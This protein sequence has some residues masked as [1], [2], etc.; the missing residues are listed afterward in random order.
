MMGT[1]AVLKGGAE[2]DA[3]NR[4]ARSLYCYLHN[5]K[6]LRKIK[7]GFWKRQRLETKISLRSEIE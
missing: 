1:R 3:F 2:F 4:Y 7:R 6:A 5:T